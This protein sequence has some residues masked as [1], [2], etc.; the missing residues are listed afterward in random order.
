FEG[1]RCVRYQD[2]VAAGRAAAGS[3][4]QVRAGRELAVEADGFIA[5]AI[6]ALICG[7]SRPGFEPFGA[8]GAYPVYP[9]AGVVGY[10]REGDVPEEID[11]VKSELDPLNVAPIQIKLDLRTGKK[12]VR[13][14]DSYFGPGDAGDAFLC[15]LVVAGLALPMF[16]DQAAKQFKGLYQVRLLAPGTVGSLRDISI[17]R[18]PFGI[19]EQRIIV[20]VCGFTGFDGGLE[21]F[22]HAPEPIHVAALA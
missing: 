6:V 2:D 18:K 22:G 19:V 17:V 12:H 13:G 16:V 5:R 10:I 20:P 7:L 8:G 1:Q 11:L 3:F 15:L 4:D 21:L 14:A 9:C